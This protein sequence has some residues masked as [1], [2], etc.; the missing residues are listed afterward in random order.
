MGVHPSY[1]L[2][3]KR[4]IAKRNR[5]RF[6]GASWGSDI[7]RSGAKDPCRADL[8]EAASRDPAILRPY[9]ASSNTTRR[10]KRGAGNDGRPHSSRSQA[11]HGTLAPGAH[12]AAVVLA[13]HA[14][15]VQEP[16]ADRRVVAVADRAH[17]V[18][19]VIAKVLGGLLA[20]DVPLI[21]HERDEG[22]EGTADDR[23]ERPAREFLPQDRG[24]A[25]TGDAHDAT[26]SASVF[27]RVP[28]IIGGL[29]DTAM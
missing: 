6:G 16:L 4:S 23:P 24:E 10:T 25:L 7:R 3:R 8:A 18:S 9:T 11:S 26:I 1:R 27:E 19:A 15:A 29:T 21:R 5:L 22:D 20:H 17:H 13:F 28:N 2:L 12:E 14:C